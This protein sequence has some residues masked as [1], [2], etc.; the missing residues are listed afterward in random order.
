MTVWKII[1]VLNVLNFRF[2]K[3]RKTTPYF[4]SQ[5]AY[6]TGCNFNV[7]WVR[8]GALSGHVDTSRRHFF[9]SSRICV[10][11]TNR[12]RHTDLYRIRQ[13]QSRNRF[14][15]SGVIT[16]PFF[17]CSGF[18]KKTTNE[19][20]ASMNL[21]YSLW[22]GTDEGAF[23]GRTSPKNNGWVFFISSHCFCSSQLFGSAIV[24]AIFFSWQIGNVVIKVTTPKTVNIEPSRNVK[25][26]ICQ[27]LPV[28][29]LTHVL[30]KY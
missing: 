16:L 24:S 6:A 21:F 18:K 27:S 28:K 13:G 9:L 7:T 14:F 29:C 2:E 15:F 30:L 12:S 20:N 26:D 23:H 19:W 11:T 3:H 10:R 1:W 4:I 5:C 8:L 22:I 25:H 17:S